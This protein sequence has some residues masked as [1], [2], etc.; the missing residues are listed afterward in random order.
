MFFDLF[1]FKAFCASAIE[2][3]L[4]LYNNK[5]ENKSTTAT[6]LGFE[7]HSCANL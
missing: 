6:T 7:P 3:N 5:T 1:R 2:H 4:I